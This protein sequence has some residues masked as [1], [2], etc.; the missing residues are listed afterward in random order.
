MGLNGA[1]VA[2]FGPKL[3]QNDAPDL[4]I[5]FQ[6]LL[7]PKTQLKEIKN[8]ENYQNPD[9]TV[10]NHPLYTE[11]PSFTVKYSYFRPCLGSL[12]GVMFISV[13]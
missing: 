8:T 1:Q 5:I 13:F 10:E 12:A 9:F 11:I 3:C 7:G 4:R 6:A 2:L